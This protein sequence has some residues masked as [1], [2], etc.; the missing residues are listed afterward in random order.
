MTT[1]RTNMEMNVV[2]AR[3]AQIQ[4]ES[5]YL[6]ALNDTMTQITQNTATN[7]GG[8]ASSFE[9]LLYQTYATRGRYG[10]GGIRREFL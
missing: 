8:P 3:Q 6:Q 4:L 7:P 1:Q 10:S 2:S 9:S 5:Q